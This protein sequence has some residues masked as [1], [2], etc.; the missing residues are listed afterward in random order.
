[1]SR[2]DMFI[3]PWTLK[4]AHV[5][6]PGIFSKIV[7][8]VCQIESRVQC[9]MLLAESYNIFPALSGFHAIQFTLLSIEKR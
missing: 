9:A 5:L 3:P 8:N 6:I 4:C 2:P 1:M 7:L